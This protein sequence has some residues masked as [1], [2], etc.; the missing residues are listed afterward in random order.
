MFSP[1]RGVFPPDKHSPHCDSCCSCGF[2]SLYPTKSILIQPCRSPS[3][4][5]CWQR[6]SCFQSLYISSPTPH[7]HPIK[8][9]ATRRRCEVCGDHGPLSGSAL[10][11]CLTAGHALP[12]RSSIL[13][14]P[15]SVS[16]HHHHAV[17][18]IIVPAGLFQVRGLAF[19]HSFSTKST[20]AQ[21]EKGVNSNLDTLF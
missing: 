8:L 21:F 18:L 16:L 20:E 6:Q 3:L 11:N 4:L 17:C 13:A 12:S 7:F 2:G 19:I 15:P 14:C 5:S 1:H 9:E 10:W